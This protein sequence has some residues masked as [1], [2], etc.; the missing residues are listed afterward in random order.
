MYSVNILFSI[1]FVVALSKSPQI[2]DISWDYL[3]LVSQWPG[4]GCQSQS[5]VRSIS[6]ISWWTLHGLWPQRNDGTWPA[7][8]GGSVFNS[9]A[10]IPLSKVMYQY[11]PSYYQTDSTSFWDH[12]YT[13]HGTCALDGDA[14]ILNEYD[15]FS[16]ALDKIRAHPMKDILA[17]AS[18]TPSDDETYTSD[19]LLSAIRSSLGYN[20]TMV[21]QPTTGLLESISI[22]FGKDLQLIDCKD[23]KRCTASSISYP[24]W[25]N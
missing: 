15:Y 1:F 16:L 17:S 11:W 8:C 20:A 6:S 22:C 2:K 21:C 9:S 25:Q 7:T 12:E 24:T 19:Q 13:K 5:C 23:D 10:I 14:K 4:S 18:I 3:E